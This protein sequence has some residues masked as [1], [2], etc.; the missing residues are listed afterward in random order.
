L[1]NIKMNRLLAGILTM[2]ILISGLTVSATEIMPVNKETLINEASPNDE[3]MPESGA[4]SGN[5]LLLDDDMAFDN[6]VT[7]AGV[8]STS[9]TLSIFDQ[10]PNPN[11][12]SATSTYNV[13]DNV[14][15]Y[16]YEDTG[17]L[18]VKGTG[19]IDLKGNH[20]F[21]NHV[22]YPIREGIKSVYITDGITG[23]GRNF[24]D[25]NMIINKFTE[26]TEIRLPETLVWI[27]ERA[28]RRLE[29]LTTINMP[30]SL[31]HIGATAFY[32]NKEMVV[33]RL[34][35]NLATIGTRAFSSALKLTVTELPDT[36]TDIA[37]YGFWNSGIAITKM[38]DNLTVIRGASFALCSNLTTLD[39][40]NV[41]TILDSPGT[42]TYGA[43]YMTRLVAVSGNKVEY[44]GSY[45]FADCGRLRTVNLPK[46]SHLGQQAFG[47]GL[48]A[49]SVTHSTGAVSHTERYFSVTNYK[50]TFPLLTADNI[51]LHALMM[52]IPVENRVGTSDGK[53]LGSTFIYAFPGFEVPNPRFTLSGPSHAGYTYTG[54]HTTGTAEFLAD[55]SASPTLY[56]IYK[57]ID[58]FVNYLPN[59][60]T[61]GTVPVD[62]NAYN[63]GDTVTVKGNPGD[64]RRSGFTFHGWN[65]TAG[66][67]GINYIG[68]DT[69]NIINTNTVNLHARWRAR[70]ESFRTLMGIEVSYS[71]SR[72]RAGTEIHIPA[73]TVTGIYTVTFDNGEETAGVRGNRIPANELSLNNYYMG[74][75]EVSHF[76]VTHIPSGFMGNFSVSRTDA[77]WTELYH[78]TATWNGSDIE[79]GSP[80]DKADITVIPTYRHAWED[81]TFSYE[82]GSPANTN[83][84]T[85]YPGTVVNEGSNAVAVVYTGNGTRKVD[86]I[87]INGYVVLTKPEVKVTYRANGAD[88]GLVP[89]NEDIYHAGDKLTVKGNTGSLARSGFTFNGWNTKEN[90]TG[91]NYVAGDIINIED[92]NPVS[93]YARWKPRAEIER[94]ISGITVNY[95]LTIQRAGTKINL[96][97]LSVTGIYTIIYDNGE[98]DKNVVGTAIPISDISLSSN[99]INNSDISHFTVTHTP[100][101]HTGYFSVTKA[102]IEKTELSHITASYIGGDVEVGIKVDKADIAVTPTYRLTW[103]DKA[104]TYLIGDAVNHA[105]FTLNPSIII[106]EGVNTL[107]VTYSENGKR[108]F[109]QITVIG[110]IVEIPPENPEISVTYHPN[111]ADS[112]VVPFDGNVYHIGGN[113][114]VKANSGNLA[115]SGYTFDGWNVWKSGMGV[116]YT[117]GDVIDINNANPIKLYARWKPRS[118]T[119][120]I[121]TGITVNYNHT[122]QRAGTK[123][124]LDDLSVIGIYTVTF[125]N[126]EEMKNVIGNAISISEISLNVN[127]ISDLETTHFT[128]THTPSGHKGYFSVTKAGIEKTELNHITASY[129]G[130]DVEV[131]NKVGKADITVIPTYRLTWEDKTITYS[132]GEAVNPTNFTLFPDIINNKGINKFAVTYSE[133]GKR[134]FD[135]ISVTG[136][137]VEIPPENPEIS[138]TYH[139]N[140][141]DSGIVPLD[142]NIYFIGDN[143]TIKDNSGNL[144]KIGYTFDGWNVWRSGKGVNYVAGDVID[145]TNANPINIYAR[146]KPRTEAER[147]LT[148]ITVKYGLT[149]QRAGTKIN[150][151]EL[152]VNGI[153]TIIYDNGEKV[154]DVVGKAILISEISLNS[155]VIDDSDVSH[156][157]V[158]HTSSGHKGYFSVTKAEIEKTELSHITA[159]YHGDKVE[160]GMAIDKADIAVTPTYRHVWEDG[161]TSYVVEDTVSADSLALFPYFIGKEGTNAIAV[162]YSEGGRSM[163]DIINVTGFE[164]EPETDE[165]IEPTEPIEPEP[166]PTP[167][168]SPKPGNGKQPDGG[169]PAVPE[170][171]AEGQPNP[172]PDGDIEVNSSVEPVDNNRTAIFTTAL[173]SQCECGGCD[174][175][176][177]ELAESQPNIVYGCDSVNCSAEPCGV[178]V[179]EEPETALPNGDEHG[180]DKGIVKIVAWVIIVLLIIAIIYAIWKYLTKNSNE[181]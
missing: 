148:G 65:I 7:V 156:F 178:C 70:T 138:V 6:A 166:T 34:P 155:K 119:K 100:S 15:A 154:T 35:A 42:T 5:E 79:V 151:D 165:P 48:T 86:I 137:I 111:S 109:D 115:R 63:V 13:G 36:L 43:F 114:I 145:I 26:I 66:G 60:A 87:N 162:R 99:I 120:R 139:P 104:T 141:A 73:L 29:S 153:Y 144:S 1:R 84:Y 55:G 27:G 136:Y 133:N 90:G 125:D 83:T 74:N 152:S 51:G 168:P 124:N 4:V 19:D 72:Q 169:N 96:D 62:D 118:E 20:T 95:N 121:L 177:S 17:L 101:G 59:G 76:T 130:G 102:G 50:E 135:Q 106:S 129:I 116:N 149:K 2:L 122:K 21:T 46:V 93:L 132:N 147:T 12:V 22:L 30:D 41:T 71:H 163:F 150:L 180:V 77:L 113:V 170:P 78:I 14:T 126:G 92:D 38:P 44:I 174:P 80:I 18:Y 181:E 45:A 131:G 58:V 110:Y 9:G 16:F 24:L 158:T 123:I 161:S 11:L 167:K 112:G 85:T 175:A 68:G 127:I 97:E 105:D 37:E 75:A 81:G 56:R 164:R 94:I 89:I 25:D 53:L 146:W 98:E 54:N 140:G 88:S 8:M 108:V 142:K 173:P 23:I 49:S 3:I 159:T 176:V 40:N 157:S 67:S 69:F 57:E 160:M 39:L 28:F 179:Y 32:E 31:T 52:R 91:I 61:S 103:E 10:D 33:T 134:V 107:A 172:L 143:V 47:L 117:A 64:L 171:K 128:V 82:N